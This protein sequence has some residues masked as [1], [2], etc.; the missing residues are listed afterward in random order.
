MRHYNTYG[1]RRK[2]VLL[3]DPLWWEFIYIRGH[4][5][6]VVLKKR[7]R[8]HYIMKYAARRPKEVARLLTPELFS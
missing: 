2:A 6:V 1:L 5:E 3:I 8:Q 4:F 7:F